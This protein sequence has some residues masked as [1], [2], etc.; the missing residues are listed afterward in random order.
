MSLFKSFMRS[1][2]GKTFSL[3]RVQV[4]KALFEI[5]EKRQIDSRWKYQ[6]RFHF[7]V[8]DILFTDTFLIDNFS[9]VS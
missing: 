3:Q 6:G 8:F 5:G 4:K 9:K 7:V 2:K 1:K